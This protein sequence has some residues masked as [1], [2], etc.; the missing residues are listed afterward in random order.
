MKTNNDYTI[1]SVQK[2]L[3]VL[4]L[5]DANH[6]EM[7]LTEISDRANMR[8]GTMLR[9]LETL[10]EEDFVRYNSRI[11]KYQ[12]GI[13]I[14]SLS[15][16][17]FF[18]NNIIDVVRNQLEEPIKE[19]N[20]VGHLAV[21]REGKIILIDRILPNS[22]YSVYDL[23]STVGGEIE[24]HCTGVGKVLVAFT[25]AATREKILANCSFA[26]KSQH[27]ITDRAEYA[28]VIREV[29]K[30]GYAVNFGENEEYLKCI[31]Y[32]IFNAAGEGIA[33][34]SLTGVIQCF[35]PELEVKCHK[36]L[37]IVTTEASR[38]FGYQK[39]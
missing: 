36:I 13:A 37:K 26:R 32:P 38:E 39:K 30:Q 6:R 21:L 5:F 18:F 19:L 4:K 20:M 27:T 31:T 7:S 23:N 2:A 3:K 10:R 25:N 15:A 28:K 35:T 33:A 9:V 29:Q 11:K 12:L 24:A 8:K 34:L 1:A 17:A 22:N 16:S 14:Y